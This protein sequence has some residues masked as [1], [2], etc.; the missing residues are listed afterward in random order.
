MNHRHLFASVLAAC[1][2]TFSSLGQ[3][4]HAMDNAL[5]GTAFEGLMSGLAHPVIGLDHLLFV[6]AMGAASFWFG[7]RPGS[8]AVFVAAAI[9]GTG[10]HLAQLTVPYA[11]VLV[12]ASLVVLGLLI[13]RGGPV[14]RSGAGPVF[15]ALA[16]LAH[17][18]AYGESIVGAEATP[19]FAYLAGFS[20]IQVVI[21]LGAYGL[22]RRMQRRRSRPF[23]AQAVGGAASVAG[24]AFMLLA[25]SA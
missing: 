5:P 12:A 10:A 23:P 19:L 15:F 11:E 2:A 6:L 9:A 3:A 17:G 25:L 4:H 16:G 1:A 24:I 13:L 22:A 21:A 7:Q 14:L 20:L 8:I 18:Y